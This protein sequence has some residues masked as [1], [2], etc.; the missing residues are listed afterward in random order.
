VDIAAVSGRYR[1]PGLGTVALARDGE[2]L[3]VRQGSGPRHIVYPVGHAT[4]YVPG[5][6][7]YLP[8]GPAGELHW[9]SLLHAGLGRRLTAS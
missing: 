1:L 7:A 9:D 5:L 2:R 8:V 4:L 3:T 6:D